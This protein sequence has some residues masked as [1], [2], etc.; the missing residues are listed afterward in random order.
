MTHDEC[1]EGVHITPAS[2]D[3]LIGT[4]AGGSTVV[5]KLVEHCLRGSVVR[6]RL[7][8]KRL[9]TGG[10]GVD[11]WCSVNH[12]CGLSGAKQSPEGYEQWKYG[13]CC[14][15]FLVKIV[16]MRLNELDPPPHSWP[17][18]SKNGEW[19]LAEESDTDN[20]VESQVN[21]NM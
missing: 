2:V 3:K 6:L 5:E 15:I 7:R 16:F 11:A 21:D 19:Q 10:E 20:G 14:I 8:Q 4:S 12:R 1:R 17:E 9:N 13:W 18:L